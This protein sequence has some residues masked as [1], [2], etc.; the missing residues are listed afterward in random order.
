MVTKLPLGND[1]V[2]WTYHSPSIMCAHQCM[3]FEREECSRHRTCYEDENLEQKSLTKVWKQT[4]E[5][6]KTNERTRLHEFCSKLFYD[7][8]NNVDTEMD[9]LM[10]ETIYKNLSTKLE[11]NPIMCCQMLK[12]IFKIV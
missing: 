2:S 11:K 3:N 5:P 4:T 12:M 9:K 1:V 10:V 6:K 8:I 7:T